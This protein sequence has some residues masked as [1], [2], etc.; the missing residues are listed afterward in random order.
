MTN[1]NT[2][3]CIHNLKHTLLLLISEVFG[4]IS[5]EA[6]CYLRTLAAKAGKDGCPDRTKYDT[7]ARQIS[8]FEH[9]ARRLSAAAI[10]G[11]AHVTH[12]VEDELRQR[13]SRVLATRALNELRAEM[14]PN[15]TPEGR[16]AWP[17]LPGGDVGGE[18]GQEPRLVRDGGDAA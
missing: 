12:K 17:P 5:H 6:L 9:Y 18:V 11:D 13:L 16:A 8:F 15:D 4:G 1:I 3:Q 2:H 7:R 10:I 14:V